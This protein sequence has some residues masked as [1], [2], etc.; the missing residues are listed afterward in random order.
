MWRPEWDSNQRSFGR[1]ATNLP[2]SHHA[3]QSNPFK[4]ILGN[5]KQTLELKQF[6]FN[7]RSH[8][9]SHKNNGTC[10]VYKTPLIINRRLATRWWKTNFNHHFQISN[11]KPNQ[12]TEP[13]SI[14]SHTRRVFHVLLLPKG[15]TNHAVHRIETK[16]AATEC[17]PHKCNK[18]NKSNPRSVHHVNEN[19]RSKVS[20][21]HWKLARWRVKSLSRDAV[22]P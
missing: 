9:L 19:Q 22:I 12:R 1:K 2:K 8:L 3:P 4:A 16:S 5:G 21:K 11:N 18:L 15:T 20:C 10:S 14:L 6:S 17:V 7:R 13:D